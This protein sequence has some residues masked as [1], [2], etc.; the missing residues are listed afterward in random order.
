MAIVVL[1]PKCLAGKQ[2]CAC[3]QANKCDKL[4]PIGS[5]GQQTFVDRKEGITGAQSNA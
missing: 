3:W 5:I 1:R 2:V 4:S